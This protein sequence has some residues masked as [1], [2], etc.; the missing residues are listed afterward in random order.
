MCSRM[1]IH[2]CSAEGQAIFGKP[3][4]GGRFL[5]KWP[6]ISEWTMKHMSAKSE[7]S[8][9]SGESYMSLYFPAGWGDLD[10][11][12]LSYEDAR[13]WRLDICTSI[14]VRKPFDAH[15]GQDLSRENEWRVD[16]RRLLQEEVEK[17]DLGNGTFHLFFYWHTLTNIMLFLHTKNARPRVPKATPFRSSDAGNSR[18]I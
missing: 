2:F 6:G 10:N 11:K 1:C 8:T 14:I 18:G 13:D 7:S 4:P 3:R 12:R 15:G 5:L 9:H 16:L 17:R